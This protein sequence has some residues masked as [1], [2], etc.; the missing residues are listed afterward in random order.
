WEVNLG[1]VLTAGDEWRKLLL[2]TTV[3]LQAGRYGSTSQ[4]GSGWPATR[5]SNPWLYN[6]FLPA[7][8]DRV[9]ALSNLEALLRYGDT[10]SSPLASELFRLCP[11]NCADVRIRRLVTTRSAD[12]DQPGVSPWLYDPR[13]PNYPYLVTGAPDQAPTGPPVPFP[14]LQLRSQMV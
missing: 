4:L 7:D 13:D 11:A 8:G 12:F 9:F 14:A 5:I 10:G 6:V 2:G 1:R 3:P